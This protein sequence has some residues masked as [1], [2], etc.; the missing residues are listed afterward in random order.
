LLELLNKPVTSAAELVDRIEKPVAAHTSK[1]E[2]YDD[3]TL[4]A[5]RR[6]PLNELEVR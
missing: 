6:I 3:I 4:F 5:I 2:Q 1:A